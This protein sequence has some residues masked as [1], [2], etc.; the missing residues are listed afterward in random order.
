MVQQMQDYELS[1][2]MP[3]LNEERTVGH[4]VKQAVAFLEAHNIHGEVVVAD[5][6]S[7]DQSPQRAAQAGARVITVEEKGYGNALRAAF[8][9]A[10]GEY[11][12]MGDTDGNH[13]MF[14]LS[15]FVEHLHAGY[16]F[17]VGNRFAG[18]IESG[19]MPWFRRYIGNPVLSSIGR[20]LFPTPVRDFHCGLRGIRRDA[21]YKMK[22]QSSGMELASE[23]IIKASLLQLRVIEV[24]TRQLQDDPD[25]QSHLNPLRD[26]WRHLRFLLLYSPR[27]LFFYP[28]ISMLTLGTLLSL[29]LLVG[30]VSFGDGIIDFH[31]LIYAG[32]FSIIGLS[33]LSFAVITRIYAYHQHLLPP[34]SSTAMIYRFF[35]LERGVVLGSLIFAVGVMVLIFTLYLGLSGQFNDLSR[36]NTVRLVYGSSLSMI[37]GSQIVFTSFVLGVLGLQVKDES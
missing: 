27:W 30:P 36:S 26:G 31:T 9:A 1:I 3:C 33:L 13:D 28:A 37:A 29:R 2:V 20:L 12:I 4:V 8:R 6:G 21:I 18:G 25:R 22:L 19:A 35:T 34:N 17:V 32:T 16:D 10:R 15:A 24:P 5:N 7:T 11:I 23:M 14:D